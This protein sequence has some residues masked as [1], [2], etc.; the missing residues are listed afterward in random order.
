LPASRPR[1][2]SLAGSTP[3]EVPRS[4][5]D[6]GL[7]PDEPA[8]V[9]VGRGRFASDEV[10]VTEHHRTAGS[11]ATE[12]VAERDGLAE[13]TTERIRSTEQTTEHVAE[14]DGFAEQTKTERIEF[15]LVLLFVLVLVPASGLLP[16]PIDLHTPRHRGGRSGCCHR[17]HRNGSKGSEDDDLRQQ[18]LRVIL[19]RLFQH[20]H[21]FRGAEEIKVR[22]PRPQQ[23]KPSSKGAK[24]TKLSRARILV[25]SA[26][27]FFG[28]AAEKRRHFLLHAQ[29]S[30]LS[31][32]NAGVLCQRIVLEAGAWTWGEES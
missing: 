8:Y 9:E 23:A 24:P 16:V 6:S 26:I 27:L 19:L 29:K 28:C 21:T 25:A 2:R 7:D 14:R 20:G 3:E 11:A 15:I 10:S 30:A 32:P 18:T 13:Q 12:H 22:G 31:T 4:G 5:A 17:G 1:T